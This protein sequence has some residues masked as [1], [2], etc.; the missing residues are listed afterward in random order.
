MPGKSVRLEVRN[1]V[2]LR[3]D[4]TVL[5]K[6]CGR[7]EPMSVTA[8]MR[9]YTSQIK[10]WYVTSNS[11]EMSIP[12][13]PVWTEVEEEFYRRRFIEFK[14]LISRAVSEADKNRLLNLTEDFHLSTGG[15]LLVVGLTRMR[16]PAGHNNKFYKPFV[17]REFVARERDAGDN[18]VLIAADST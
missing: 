6:G 8:M 18:A 1:L 4:L 17:H 2:E 5:R 7:G 11:V 12:D 13:D 14:D 10:R 9:F 15:G 16:G 3:R